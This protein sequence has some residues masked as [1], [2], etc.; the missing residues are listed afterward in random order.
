MDIFFSGCVHFSPNAILK[1]KLSKRH[2][3]KSLINSA[4]RLNNEHRLY[5][6][7]LSTVQVKWPERSG[8]DSLQILGIFFFTTA[9]RTALR[10][11]QPPIQWVQGADSLVLK[12]SGHEADHSPPTSAAVKNTR[13]Y[14]STAPILLHGVV[15][16]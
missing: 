6:D 7:A 12:R 1:K 16:H 2:N 8:F 14:T 10:P 5:N 9:S 13:S 15:L 4:Q 3:P 11:N